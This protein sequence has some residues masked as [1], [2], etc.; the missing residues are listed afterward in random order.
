MRFDER[1]GAE[2][3]AFWFLDLHSFAHCSSRQMMGQGRGIDIYRLEAETL[4]TANRLQIISLLLVIQHEDQ[5]RYK[6]LDKAGTFN[7]VILATAEII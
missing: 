3:V 2:H 7:L 6:G 4:A 5:E 1:F